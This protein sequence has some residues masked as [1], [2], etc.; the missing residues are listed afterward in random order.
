MADLWY[1]K[2]F[3][4]DS[5]P[6]Q[7]VRLDGKTVVV[8][9]FMS[10]SNWDRCGS[11]AADVGVPNVMLMYKRCSFETGDSSCCTLYAKAVD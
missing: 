1:S 4:V 2:K 6:K 9:E 3:M 10:T 8:F 5:H 11:G 7:L